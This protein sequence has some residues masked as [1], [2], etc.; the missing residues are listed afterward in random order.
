MG[1]TMT[2]QQRCQTNVGHLVAFCSSSMTSAL[3]IQSISVLAACCTDCS[4]AI[5]GRQDR[6]DIKARE[7]RCGRLVIGR[8]AVLS[9]L[10]FVKK[11]LQLPNRFRFLLLFLKLYDS[12]FDNKSC[13]SNETLHQHQ[14]TSQY[15]QT[16]DHTSSHHPICTGADT[17]WPLLTTAGVAVGRRNHYFVTSWPVWWLA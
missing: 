11:I 6:S 17:H 7:L 3:H 8:P 10:K 14:L 9:C 2:A 5:D 16:N 12:K 15:N 13:G 4:F 1:L